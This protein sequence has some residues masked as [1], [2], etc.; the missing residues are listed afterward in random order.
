MS[1]KYKFHNPEA[2]YYITF[3]TVNW[4][5][6]FT[7]N[8]YKDILI[9]SFRHCIEKKGL[10]VYA[11]TIMTNHVHLIAAARGKEKLENILRDMK[12]FTAFEVIRAIINNPQESRRE[13][14]LELFERAGK[15]NS[16][17]GRYQFWQQ[18]NHP[19]ELSSNEMM[20]Q[21]LDYIHRNAVESGIVYEPHHYIY[22]S[23]GHY[24]GKG[25]N[26]L[27]VKSLN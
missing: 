1:V 4:V 14:L 26:L 15:A 17:N 9:N 16:H 3:A 12:K 22:S 21:K 5:D 27:P 2:L 20:E 18:D 8:S 13:W 25:N 24:A 23:A 11:Y 6:V 7:R 19:V 10:E